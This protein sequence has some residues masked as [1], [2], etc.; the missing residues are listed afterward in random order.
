MSSRYAQISC[1]LLLCLLLFISAALS[2]CSKKK[3]NDPE[4]QQ[5]TEVKSVEETIDTRAVVFSTDSDEW[6]VQLFKEHLVYS[7]AVAVKLPAPWSIPTR[8]E[9]T[10]LRTLTYEFGSERFITCDGYTFAMPS[11]SVTKAGQKTQYSV[12]GLWR[13]R[14]TYD[15]PF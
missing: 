3:Q 13:R 6:T 14:N 9:A 8:E 12:L 2:G 4:Q 15:I 1:V 5:D 11:S 7:E 10:I